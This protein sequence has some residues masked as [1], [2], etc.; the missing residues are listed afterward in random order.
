MEA[1]DL[2]GYVVQKGIDDGKPVT[3]LQLLKILYFIQLQSIKETGSM[4]MPNAIFEA[5][6]FGPVITEV[7]YAYC[8]HG[9]MPIYRTEQVRTIFKNVPDFV[10]K[11]I[12]KSRTMKTWQLVALSHC[13]NGA[14]E[15]AYIPGRS[16]I[17]RNSDMEIESRTFSMEA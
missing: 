12:E 13:T 10:N 8:L 4:I 2:A 11:I 3:N 1:L 5:W 7:Y 17:I 6:R 9:S 14:W 16:N 15:K